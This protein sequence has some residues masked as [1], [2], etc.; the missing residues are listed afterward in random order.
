MLFSLIKKRFP[1]API[2]K[3]K[4]VGETGPIHGAIKA[5]RADIVVTLGAR[6]FYID[7][8]TIDPGCE[9]CLHHPINSAT[10]QD[11]SARSRETHKRKHYARVITPAP[12]PAESIIPFVIESSGRLGPSALSFLFTI[13][14]TQT[15]L[16]SKFISA[17]STLCARYIGKT[18]KATRDRFCQYV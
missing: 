15:F 17:I 16:R 4:E 14:G 7:V 1:Q 9:T 5:V 13:C 11:A 8:S 10:T 6:T 2:W 12:L 18:L 3:E